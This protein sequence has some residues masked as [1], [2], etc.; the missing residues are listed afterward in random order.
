MLK[1]SLTYIL[2]ILFISTNA[3]EVKEIK[4]TFRGTRFVNAQ[5]TNLADNGDLL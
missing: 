1:P 3:Q 4:N 5:S 2:V